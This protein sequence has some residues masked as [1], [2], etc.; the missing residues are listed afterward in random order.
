MITIP[1]CIATVVLAW[2]LAWFFGWFGLVWHGRDMAVD[3]MPGRCLFLRGKTRR[4]FWLFGLYGV[5][6]L[7]WAAF[8]WLLAELVVVFTLVFPIAGGRREVGVLEGAKMA[9][10]PWDGLGLI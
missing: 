4:C 1:N 6:W 10:V 2:F 7:H 3:T 5:Y 8:V 9:V